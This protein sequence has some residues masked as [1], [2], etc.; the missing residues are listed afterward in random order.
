MFKFVVYKL[1]L[2]GTILFTTHL[3]IDWYIQKHSFNKINESASETV[4]GLQVYKKQY[5]LLLF[6]NHIKATQLTYY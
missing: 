6:K 3:S 2:E 5:V 1:N 4:K